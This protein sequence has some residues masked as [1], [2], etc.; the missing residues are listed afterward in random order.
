M[1]SGPAAIIPR[2]AW[3]LVLLVIIGNLLYGRSRAAVL[4]TAGKVSEEEL[5]GFVRGAFFLLGGAFA[6]MFL[7]QTAA[8]APDPFCLMQFPP[9]QTAG[10]MLW[11][12][13]AL[14]SGGLVYWIWARGGDDLL[15]R[16]A[17]AF[18]QG[19]VLERSFSPTHV[20][21]FLTALAILAPAGNLIMQL[22]GGMPPM[23]GCVSNRDDG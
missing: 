20:R 22:V 14:L 23:P 19:P 21:Y 16:L 7:L 3:L 13:Q 9:R 12:V 5:S 15:A 17:P 1:T 6:L 18:T 4:V 2:Y 8:G 10:W 11:T